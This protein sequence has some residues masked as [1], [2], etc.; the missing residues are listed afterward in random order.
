MYREAPQRLWRGVSSSPKWSCVALVPSVVCKSATW[1]SWGFVSL[2]V[3]VCEWERCHGWLMNDC[4][5]VPR[6][7]QRDI[8]CPLQVS[9]KG[10]RGHPESRSGEFEGKLVRS[11]LL[12]L[13]QQRSVICTQREVVFSWVKSPRASAL[14]FGVCEVLS[15]PSTE[16]AVSWWTRGDGAGKSPVNLNT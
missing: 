1:G 9:E 4:V 15:D 8:H 14:L 12:F 11:I 3:S 13:R 16:A 5:F 6:S 2:W 7:H 10:L